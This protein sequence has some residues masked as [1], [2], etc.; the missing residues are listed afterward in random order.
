MRNTTACTH[1]NT[2]HNAHRAEIHSREAGL[3]KSIEGKAVADW[4]YRASSAAHARYAQTVRVLIGRP[5]DA[6]IDT[7]V[8][9][10]VIAVHRVHGA[11]L[12]ARRST[13]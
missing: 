12:L 7:E 3:T 8:I 5:R 11:C 6:R 9:S 13:P 10:A 1:R 4:L 2:Q